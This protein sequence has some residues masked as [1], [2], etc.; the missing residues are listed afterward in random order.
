MAVW[1][2]A[3]VL[4]PVIGPVLGGWLTNN[5]SWPWVFYINVS[6]GILSFIGLL[7][8]LRESKVGRS[9]FAFFG[10]VTVSLA[11]GA[12]QVMRDCGQLIDWFDSCEICLDAAVGAVSFSLFLMQSFTAKAPFISP[13]LFKDR[14]FAASNV[15]IFVFGAALFATLRLLPPLLQELMRHPVTTTGLV[16]APR[17]LGTLISMIAVGRLIER[18]DARILT[19]LGLG[20]IAASLWQMSGFSPQMNAH[21]VILSGFIQEIGVGF[22]YVPAEHHAL[23]HPCASLS[24][25]GRIAVQAAAQYWQ[26]HWNLRHA[27]RAHA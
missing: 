7:T 18:I 17:G 24:L 15:V 21:L 4:G 3:V 12:L 13:H 1:G 2:M 6:V 14:S 26:Q 23:R 8:V 20:L 22:T 16:T 25:R 27:S 19:A 10:F 9:R 5:D 11:I